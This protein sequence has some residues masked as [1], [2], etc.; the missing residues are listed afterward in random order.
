MTKD[1]QALKLIALSKSIE[2]ALTEN[3]GELLK[4]SLSS[5]P[6]QIHLDSATF[7]SVARLARPIKPEAIYAN[8]SLQARL[9]VGFIEFAVCHNLT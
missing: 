2:T 9:R 1:E 4:D 5:T 8:A 3:D 6:L 7:A